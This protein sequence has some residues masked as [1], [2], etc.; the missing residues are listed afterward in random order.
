MVVKF[1]TSDKSNGNKGSCSALANYLEKEDLQSE[2][3]AFEKG[4]LPAP[5]TG[6]FSHENDKL[7][8]AEVIY[9]IDKN[10]KG[11]G[12]DDSKFY[13]ITIA[14]SEREQKHIINEIAP[15]KN[16]NS[17]QD[18]NKE[19]IE[20]FETFLKDYS[21]NIMN[22][23]ASHYNRANLN[24]GNQ[25]LY[26]GKI[27][28][29]R[30]YKGNDSEVI[31][32]LAK[33]NERKPGLNSHIHIIVSRKDREMKYKLSPLANDK[34]SKKC[35]TNGKQTQRGFDRNLFNIKAETVF[36]KQFNYNRSLNEKVE[37]R[38]EAT[39]NS[40]LES[41]IKLKSEHKE[42]EKFEQELIKSYDNRNK[43]TEKDKEL[44]H[45]IEP[46][47]NKEMSNKKQLEL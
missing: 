1:Q 24:N 39:K 25:L 44:S 13:A 7:S 16:V 34:G 4:E 46:S 18:L 14:P 22:E 37:Y 6:F 23:Y 26:Y 45:K 33:G 31:N 5:R 12:K 36:D 42:K 30:H 2:K 17:I 19:Q 15:G 11:L 28:H 40:I 32:G 29:Q 47:I 21:R 43:L 3:E 38:I 41:R 10:K 9:E 27:E 20:K 8:K 35:I